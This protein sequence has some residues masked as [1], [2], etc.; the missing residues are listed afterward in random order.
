MRA[1]IPFS[2]AGYAQF[3]FNTTNARSETGYLSQPVVATETRTDNYTLDS[4]LYF[5]SHSQFQ[6]SNYLTRTEQGGDRPVNEWRYSPYLRW[7]HSDNLESY[8][9]MNY[10]SSDQVT[11][12]S[13]DVGAATGFRYKKSDAL[14]LNGEVH[15]DKATSTGLDLNSYGV[16]GN[17]AYRKEYSFGV[18]NFSAGLG[19]DHFNRVANVIVPVRNLSMNLSGTTPAFLPNDN[20]DRAT[21]VV[22]RVFSGGTQTLLTVGVD[23]ICDGTIDILVKSIDART[24]IEN[25]NGALQGDIQVSVSYDY[26]PGGSVAYLNVN[27]SYDVN[28]QLYKNYTIYAHYRQNSV[29]IQSGMPTQPLGESKN[30]RLGARMD[31]P[32]YRSLRIGGE[33]VYEK[34][35]GTLY[36]YV[37]DSAEVHFQFTLLGG[38]FH[39][40]TQHVNTDYANTTQ[41][42]NLVRNTL[43]FRVRPWNRVGLLAELSQEDQTSGDTERR[44]RVAVLTAE[45][46]LRKLNMQAEARRVLDT[47]GVTDRER[48]LVRFILRRDF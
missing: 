41:D 21:I 15:G 48:S 19:A 22:Y 37:R 34:E 16:T 3:V 28:L 23:T 44:T 20:I 38:L 5:G 1:Q 2:Q 35:D 45:W 31:Y 36:S 13:R 6:L 43:Q 30:R 17:L 9:R 14:G 26:N 27:Q 24:T 47:Y 33:V 12:T 25:C 40:S 32:L 42:I 29:S 10:L 11:V 8:Y 46:R 4:R 7:I 18:F 39:A